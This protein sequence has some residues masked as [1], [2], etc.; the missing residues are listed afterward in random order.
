[1][2]KENRSVAT[3]FHRYRGADARAV[4]SEMNKNKLVIENRSRRSV[5]VGFV[6]VLLNLCVLK[7][8]LVMLDFSSLSPRTPRTAACRRVR[9]S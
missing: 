4:A 5:S 6:M 3:Q 7:N 9:Q 8:Q 2:I 1:M